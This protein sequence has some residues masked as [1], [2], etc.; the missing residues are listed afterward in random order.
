MADC[1]VYAGDLDAALELVNQARRIPDWDRWVLAWSYYFKAR[2]DDHFYN[3]ALSELR[4]MFRR[5][6]EAKYL[7]E[8]KLLEAAIHAQQGNSG[9]AAAALSAFLKS[10]PGWTVA[11]E[12]ARSPFAHGLDGNHWDD[13]LHKAGLP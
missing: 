1:L 9:E 6:G 7:F 2:N 5:P 8:T 10:K 13:G 12:Q 11:K 3:L 4:Q